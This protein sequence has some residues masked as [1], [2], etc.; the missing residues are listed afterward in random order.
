[1]QQIKS[2]SKPT[3]SHYPVQAKHVRNQETKTTKHSIPLQV[4]TTDLY[5]PV[6]TRSI[7]Q[8]SMK[9]SINVPCFQP[10]DSTIQQLT[11]KRTINLTINQTINESTNQ[12]NQLIN[13]IDRLINQS[14]THPTSQSTN[15]S[16]SQSTNQLID[17]ST[18]QANERP[19]HQ[20]STNQS[21][22]INVSINPPTTLTNQR[23]SNN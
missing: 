5:N 11:I 9:K 16:I 1:M 13:F 17:R 2:N 15:R 20:Q 6:V 21:L 14:H 3:R 18:S 23:T 8:R 7:N 12:S 10:I 4:L 19:I 22:N